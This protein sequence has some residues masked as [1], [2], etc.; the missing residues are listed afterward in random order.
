MHLKYVSHEM[1]KEMKTLMYNEH[2]EYKKLRRKYEQMLF[3]YF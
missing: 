2:P 1:V 3:I